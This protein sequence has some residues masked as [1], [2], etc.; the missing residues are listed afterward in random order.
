MN[1]N[2]TN[3]AVIGLP[4]ITQQLAACILDRYYDWHVYPSD[5]E[6][7]PEPDLVNLERIIG[8]FYDSLP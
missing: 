5:Y 6:S 4:R 7:D 8:E 1:D 3:A 2:I